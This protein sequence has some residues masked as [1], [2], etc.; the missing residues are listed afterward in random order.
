MIKVS[1]TSIY[2]RKDKAYIPV[3]AQTD[4]G[5]FMG[6]EPVFIC[7]LA[8]DE[9]SNNLQKV[10]DFGHPYIQVRTSEESKKYSDS[11]LKAIKAK[12]WKELARTGY[13]YTI[14]WSDKGVLIEMSRLDK[15][16]R[17]EFDPKKAKRLPID[18]ALKDIVQ[19]ILDD[20]WSRS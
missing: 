6:I 12:S 15:Q 9:L 4:S 11:I 2:I 20:Y 7:D 1:V 18:T 5:L 8:L 3:N 13:S 19:I 16:G 14:E 17:W 10:R